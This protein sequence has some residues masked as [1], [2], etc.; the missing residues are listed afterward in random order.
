MEQQ[1]QVQAAQDSTNAVNT[2]SNQ[3]TQEQANAQAAAPKVDQGNGQANTQSTEIELK[4]PENSYLNAEALEAVKSFAKDKNITAE[5]AQ[6][7]LNKQNDSLAGYHDYI[8]SEHEKTV[9]KWAEQAKA[10]QEYGG[11]NFGK[12]V[13]MAKRAL[14]KFATPQFIKDLD[15]SGYGNHPEILRVFTRIG[16]L[17]AEDKMVNPSATA[18]GSK[19]LEDVFYGK[20]Q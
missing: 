10:D 15:Q 9:S 8:L 12:N 4:L 13:E 18:V 16:K 20:Q 14:E 11:E 6:E 1:T 17:L 3:Q 7:I 2:E 19:N 5:I